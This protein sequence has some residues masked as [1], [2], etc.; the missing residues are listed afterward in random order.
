M[1]FARPSGKVG[2]M[3][4][5]DARRRWSNRALAGLAL[6][7]AA[8][9]GG[10]TAP[11]IEPA[12]VAPAAPEPDDLSP[13]DIAARVGP[14]VVRIVGKG[15]LGTGFVVREDGWIATNLHVI[16]G[17]K[18]LEVRLKDGREFTVVEVIAVDRQRDVAV[19]R[20]DAKQLEPISLGEREVSVGEPVVAIG[21]PLGLSDTVSDGLVSG[22][23]EVR[24]G[25]Q[26]LQVSAPI[27][28]GSSGGPLID[29]E[30]K[31]IGIAT[32]ILREGQNLNFGIPIG[33][34]R[35]LMES[36][37]PQSLES[38]AASMTP[39][40][41]KLPKVKRSVPDHPTSLLLGCG[42]G[43]LKE[44]AGGIVRAIEVGAPIYDRGFLQACYHLYLGASVD[45]ETKLS[46][47]CRGPRRALRDGRSRADKLSDPAAQAWAM[48]DTFDGVLTVIRKKVESQR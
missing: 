34:L 20:I 2:G 5:T 25:L 9:C 4:R 14:S 15:S 45:V 31:V 33:Y 22:V 8:A 18:R 24:D 11:P 23:R 27:A 29:R 28:P 37:E 6:T 36:P 12:P 48:R 44:L 35:A 1:V 10:A 41:P 42:D 21:H 19:V 17:S 40:L 16:A 3:G 43:D 38:L 39:K 47:S 46:A 7:G 26:V 32:A 30:G 13:Q